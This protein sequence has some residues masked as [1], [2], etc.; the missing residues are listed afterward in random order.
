[1]YLKAGLWIQI[2]FNPDPDPAF[3]LNPYL[4][5]QS[6]WIRIQY[7]SGS[8]ADLFVIKSKKYTNKHIF[9]C[10]FCVWI[11]MRIPKQDPDWIRIQ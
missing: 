9:S 1:M 4:D 6:H 2:D 3:L 11:R 8:T 7:R 10:I 5:P